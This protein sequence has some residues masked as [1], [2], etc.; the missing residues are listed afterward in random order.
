MK[1]ALHPAVYGTEAQRCSE[2]P[3]QLEETLLVL[4]TLKIHQTNDTYKI[5]V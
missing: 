3:Y 5:N 2:V 4:Q 1:V